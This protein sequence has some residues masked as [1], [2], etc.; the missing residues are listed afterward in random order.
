MH[1][2]ELSCNISPV[3]YCYLHDNLPGLIKVSNYVERTNYYSAKGI[4]QIE[5]RIFEYAKNCV[6]MKK[7]Y[8][9]LRCNPSIIMGDSKV[10]LL[11]MEKYTFA[12]IQ[13]RLMKRIYEIN[14]FRYIKLDKQ[15]FALFKTNRAD[16]AVDI[17]VDFP[18]LVV[19]L[20]NMSFPFGYRNMKR[21][22]ICKETDRLYIE[23]CCFYNGSRKINIYHKW[24]ALINTEKEILTEEQEQIQRTVRLE[25]QLEKKSIYNMQLPTKRSIVPFLKN[26]FCHEY[27]EK[28]ICS[29]FGTQKYVSRSKA[30][31]IINNSHYK[32]YDK[33]VMRSIID[34]IHRFK[35]LYELEK[36]IADLKTHTPLQYGNIRSF[37]ERWLKKFKQLGIQPVVIPDTFGV[38]ELP[39]IYELL[40]N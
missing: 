3:S 15:P 37:K 6:M 29:V 14:E 39:S 36:A 7:Y 40:K 10:F 25:V 2:F 31:E 32:P 23:S 12:E 24:I 9:V 1:T 38:D 17:L 4:M 11:D 8:L 16:V 27:L 35:G 33:A 18:Q 28:E 5:L 30:I 21:K 20:C 13:E 26:D 19:W 34:T 22:V